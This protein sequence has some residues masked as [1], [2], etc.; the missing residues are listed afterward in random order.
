VGQEVGRL[1]HEVDPQIFV[2]DADVDVA[3]ADQKAPDG[4]PEILVQFLVARLARMGLGAPVGEG[5]RRGGAGSVSDLLIDRLVFIACLS[6]KTPH[7]PS[8]FRELSGSRL[9][10]WM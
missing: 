4:E 2:L 8:P 1:V 3:A 5:M 10:S 6:S 7:H 9:F